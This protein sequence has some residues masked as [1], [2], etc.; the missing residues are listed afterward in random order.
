M[1]KPPSA[2]SPA[3]VA[4][5]IQEAVEF[6]RAGQLA[7]AEKRYARALKLH[8]GHFDALHLLGVV[9]HQ[10]G[11]LGEAYGLITSALKVNPRSA[12]AL[13]NLAMVLHGLKRDEEALASLDKALALAPNH[14][15][16]L[17]NRG[18][19]LLALQ[20]PQ[21]AAT[22]FERVLTLAPRHVEARVNRGNAF[23]A[24]ARREDAI[25]EYDAAIAIHPRHAGAH[26][27]R[28][29]ALHAVGRHGEAVA[30]FDAALAIAP[31]H[32]GAL[33]NR[34]LAYQALNRL[35]EA[36]QSCRAAIAIEPGYA[37]AHFNEALALLT[38]GELRAGFEKYEWRWT[39][40]GM[41]GH[42][43]SFGRPLWLGEYPLA[44]KTILLHA[45]QGLGDTI[46][47]VRYAPLVARTGATVV[48]EV[49][50][51]LKELLAQVEGVSRV[52]ARGDPLPA[53]D[54]H[55][56]LASLPLAF[57]TEAATVPA[58][59]PYLAVS[60]ERISKWRP[61]MESL[62]APRV[63]LA[64]SGRATHANDRQRS[65][66]LGRLA[67]L[68]EVPV[69]FVSVQRDPREPD[70][71]A[72]RELPIAHVGDDLESFTDTAA[73]LALADLVIA[74]DTSVAHLAAAMGRP[75]WTLLPFAP[76][77]RW[78][79]QGERSPWYPSARLF[80]QPSPADWDSVIATVN[81]ELSRWI[82]ETGSL[83]VRV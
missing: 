22:C 6:H 74:V 81:S 61:R 59:I 44:R 34:G 36:V 71:A 45:E 11:K 79:L 70:Q 67:P 65:I 41:E 10:R 66:P 73:V 39:R 37:D 69:R 18:N 30:A 28:G 53:F 3:Q 55:C 25:A 5:A 15:E 54:V 27:N 72:L 17:N 43:R 48:L 7:E 2:R 50:P 49:Q 21:E 16:A 56:P 1:A 29:H 33:L 62:A 9:K 42:R 77:W 23:A 47:F 40:T 4:Q 82:A 19:A 51:E 46:Q 14:L 68:F 52:V 60:G 75:T 24:L 32:A 13:A 63:A 78:T 20:R 57:R 31:K 12:D 80:R 83:A 58:A 76:D 8:P 64:W 38:R 35:D 26:F